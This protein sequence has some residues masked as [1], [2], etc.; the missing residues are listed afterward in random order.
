MNRINFITP[1]KKV[2][3]AKGKELL[4]VKNKP[5]NGKFYCAMGYIPNDHRFTGYKSAT[6]AFRTSS[7]RKD[8]RLSITPHAYKDEASLINTLQKMIKYIEDNGLA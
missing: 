4:K 8:R 1:P 6:I 7:Q 5:F 2:K 3:H